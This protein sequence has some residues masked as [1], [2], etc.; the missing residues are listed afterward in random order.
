MEKLLLIDGSNLLFQSF[1]GMPARI[2]NRNKK[3]VHGTIG[4]VGALLKIIRTVNPTHIAVLF[5]GEHANARTELDSNY[6]AN[7]PDYSLVPDEENPF[8]QLSD[9]YAALDYLRLKHAE[10]QTCETDDWIAGYALRYGKRVET[11][12][13]SFDSDYFQLLSKTVSVLRYRGLKTELFTPLSLWERFGIFPSAYA[14]FKALVG[15]SSDNIR[16][17]EKVGKKTAAR[18]LTQFS[19]LDEILENADRIEPPSIRASIVR[20]AEKLKINYRMI[21]LNDSAPLPFT[22]DELIYQKCALSST[23]VLKGTGL[24]P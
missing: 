16:G 23:E 6:K 3:A 15:D 1:F 21:K 24:L 10:T 8:S 14:D 17:A 2:F 7:R 22:L 13:S 5:D 9:I 4:F 18:L 20:N 12:I 19:S 11:V